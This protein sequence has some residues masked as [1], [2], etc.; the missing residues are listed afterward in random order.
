MPNDPFPVEFDA[1]AS[2]L[3][4][5][6]KNQVER[7]LHQLS[8]NRRDITGA[9]VAA[10][11]PAKGET[12]YLYEARIVV[13]QRPENVFAREQQDT[14]EGALKGAVQAIERQVRQNRNKRGKPWKRPDRSDP[15][16]L[17]K[18]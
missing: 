4:D 10:D 6:L 18:S 5:E 15:Q 16:E 3:T 11:E 7:D 13:Y 14:L 2:E 17:A 12:G 8:D 9:S 1:E